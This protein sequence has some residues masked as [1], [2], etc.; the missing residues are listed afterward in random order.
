MDITLDHAVDL[1]EHLVE[2]RLAE[3]MISTADWPYELPGLIRL[4]AANHLVC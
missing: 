4:Y 1:L 3:P 2:R